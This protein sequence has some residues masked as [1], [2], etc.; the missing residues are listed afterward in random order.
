MK[1]NFVTEKISEAIHI[2][3][4]INQIKILHHLYTIQRK[5]LRLIFPI[6]SFEIKKTNGKNYGMLSN[7][8]EIS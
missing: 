4:I 3:S 8:I 6:D 1:Y 2:I 5:Q 7:Q